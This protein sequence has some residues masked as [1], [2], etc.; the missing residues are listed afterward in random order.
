MSRKLTKSIWLWLCALLIAGCSQ[1]QTLTT[2]SPVQTPAVSR[3]TQT[4]PLDTPPAP[5]NT[6]T[7]DS[8]TPIATGL[9]IALTNTTS[10][11]QGFSGGIG[12]LAF[13]SNINNVY[14]IGVLDMVSGKISML[15]N[16]PD[17]GDAEPA[18]SPDGKFILYSAGRNGGS[19]FD[20]YRM[21]AD[22]TEATQLITSPRGG[23]FSPT[24]SP[25][26]SKIVFHTNRDG[27]MEVYLANSDGSNQTN[28]TNNT[29]NS[30]AASW[31]PDGS[32]IVFASDRTGDYQLYVMDANGDNVKL[33]LDHKGFSDFRPRY[34]P[35]GRLI[36]FGTQ[37]TS[38]IS[39]YHLATINSDGSNFRMITSGQSQESQAGWIGNDK[40]VFSG[41][42][43]TFE[44]W[45]LFSK[46]M[47]SSVFIRLTFGD[48]D[49]RNP[50]WINR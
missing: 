36:L 40:I 27:H 30:A 34:S 38:N 44:K 15:T 21:K 9:S 23:N 4:E 41:R 47:N 7:P 43:T 16:D 32:R 2:S 1:L 22:G 39:E 14:E 31:S 18:W 24:Y 20:I 49:Y 10:S 19:R 25:D 3:V 50:A 26:G 48:A 35:D 12:K 46:D 33:L 28:L 5:A 8:V 37:S 11:I 29:S 17:P 13:T 42:R 45:Q 6:Q